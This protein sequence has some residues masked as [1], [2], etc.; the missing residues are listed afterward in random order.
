MPRSGRW[1]R[2]HSRS[3]LDQDPARA[4][5]QS[6]ASA[7]T[8]RI[9]IA[10]FPPEFGPLLEFDQWVMDISPYAHVPRMPGADF[11]ATPMVTLTV[12][13]A[14]L[15]VARLAGFRRRERSLW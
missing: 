10:S 1:H 12:L 5:D 6:P 7:R 8:R 14:L 15:I 11:T 13:A 4:A 9:S 2:S 3:A